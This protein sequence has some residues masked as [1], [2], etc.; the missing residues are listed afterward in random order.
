MLNKK[1]LANIN[2][3]F[4]ATNN[5]IKVTEDYGSMILEAKGLANK[6][7]KDLKC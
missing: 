2:V 6:K 4:N 1:N 5:A 7:E 3:L